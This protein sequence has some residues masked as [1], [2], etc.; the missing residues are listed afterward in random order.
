MKIIMKIIYILKN[1]IWLSLILLLAVI[2]RSYGIY[3]DYPFGVNYIW[4]ETM[5][6]VYMFDIVEKRNL[7]VGTYDYPALLPWLYA[8][9]IA[10][11]IIY[12]MITNSILSIADLKQQLII[13]GMGQVYIIVRW[14]SVFYGTATI[15][16]LYKIFSIIFKNKSSVYYGCLVYAVSFIPLY[17]SHWGKAHS[18]MVFFLMLSLYF[19][20]KY[21]QTTKKKNLLWSA[22]F[23]AG[24]ISVHYIGI[25]AVIF[26]VFA[27]LTHWREL[28]KNFIFQLAI[29]YL[30]VTGLFYFGNFDGVRSMIIKTMSYFQS[31]NFTG[32]A[33]VGLAERFSYIF[34]DIFRLE[35]VFFSVFVLML[36][37]NV[38]NI[39]K[40]RYLKYILAG[41]GANYLLMTTVIV[42]PQ[43]TR[44]LLIFFTL[45]VP[46]GAILLVEKLR[47]FHVKKY[48]IVAICAILLLPS[49]YISSH[50][51]KLLDQNTENEAIVWLKDNLK[52]GEFA[53]SFDRYIDT[54]LS[55]EAMIW[56]RDHNGFNSK[57]INYMLA[58]KDKLANYGINLLYDYD[59]YRY[60][61]LGGEK[62]KYLIF[63]YYNKKDVSGYI[64]LQQI[65]KMKAEISRYHQFE[66]VAKFSPVKEKNSIP[67]NAVIDVLN[68][69]TS[70]RILLD[71]KKS[72]QFI[73]IYRLIK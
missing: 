68:N 30:A 17:L 46:L 23:A 66:L 4:D 37:V 52:T 64:S 57:K 62:T 54:P 16:L 39:F 60:E 31:T 35:P 8:P 34:R 14:Y 49:I 67:D 3:F 11:K 24:S 69:P 26:P 25:T 38:K 71:L 51:L 7:F 2:I 45:S 72:G 43:M 56:H 73:E 53:Y 61:D 63:S 9:G 1:N 6:M 18:G 10:L 70:W 19:A 48:L 42:W 65:D 44:W 5:S 55:Y 27:A 58:N 20:I 28:K 15:Y 40:D 59:K 29:L 47:D 50:W 36:I 21:E 33:K 13:S 32:M 41:L 22:T 12:I